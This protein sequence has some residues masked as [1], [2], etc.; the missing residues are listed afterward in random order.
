MTQQNDQRG[1]KI[2]LVSVIGMF[3]VATLSIAALVWIVTDQRIAVTVI[4]V[5]AT[6][7]NTAPTELLGTSEPLFPDNA[8]PLPETKPSLVTQPSST[9]ISPEQSVTVTPSLAPTSTEITGGVLIPI[10]VQAMTATPEPLEEAQIIITDD[11]ATNEFAN[12]VQ[13]ADLPIESPQVVFTKQDIQLSGQARTIQGLAPL[14]V[15]AQPVVANG[16]LQFNI[17]SMTVN[18]IDQSNSPL[19]R[20]VESELNF[21]LGRLLRGKIVQSAALQEGLITIAVLEKP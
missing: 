8:S 20:S 3:F 21:V 15:S 2:A 13:E 12:R 10:T 11:E 17:S 16:Q 6:P 4:V 1:Y 5:T 9:P 7:R 14:I 19:K 18:G